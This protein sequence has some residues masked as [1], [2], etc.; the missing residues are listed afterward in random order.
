MAAS[1]APFAADT[2][3]ATASTA[4][5][6]HVTPTGAS[7]PKRTGFVSRFL[8]DGTNQDAYQIILIMGASLFGML[9]ELI[10]QKPSLFQQVVEA[11]AWY[12]WGVGFPFLCA[13]LIPLALCP[14]Y[15]VALSR[16]FPS[17]SAAAAS[18]ARLGAITYL[19]IH[20]WTWFTTIILHCIDPS[21]PHLASGIHTLP[22][23]A[24][25]IPAA[26]LSAASNWTT[27]TSGLGLLFV[28][29]L[30]VRAA[31]GNESTLAVT[32]RSIYSAVFAGAYSLPISWL[33]EC[34]RQLD[35]EERRNRRDEY[36]ITRLGAQLTGTRR[37]RN[38]VHDHILAALVSS[39]PER[40]TP[41]KRLRSAAAEALNL[42]SRPD[43]DSRI[44]D[45]T[46]LADHLRSWCQQQ[47][48]H[49]IKYTVQ[50]HTPTAEASDNSD[51]TLSE[52]EYSEILAAALEALR[53]VAN[54][55]A[56]LD[57]HRHAQCLISISQTTDTFS[58]SITDN[59]VGFDIQQI[60]PLRLGLQGSISARMQSLL[61]GQANI[62]STVGVGTSVTLKLKRTIPDAHIDHPLPLTGEGL[63]ATVHS[64]WGRV[65]IAIITLSC[66]MH[67]AWAADS[68]AH[69]YS[70]ILCATAITIAFA[71]LAWPPTGRMRTFQQHAALLCTALGIIPYFVWHSF[72]PSLELS[73][74]PQG[75]FGILT[76]FFLH[77]RRLKL[78]LT[79]Y[80]IV[81][82]THI[83]PILV[84][85]IPIAPFVRSIAF[86]S[87][88]VLT[89][90]TVIALVRSI[91]PRISAVQRQAHQA[92][93]LRTARQARLEAETTLLTDVSRRSRPVLEQLRSLTD[94]PSDALVQLARRVE[95]ELRDLI[96]VPRLASQPALVAAVRQARD[97]G[98]D[99]I[100]LDDSQQDSDLATA[101]P[102]LPTTLID[103]ATHILHRAKNGESVVLRLCPQH[104]PYAAT[105][106]CHSAAGAIVLERIRRAS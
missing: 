58:V 95:A 104:S 63:S 57:L 85:D 92:Q 69:L 32:T 3:S 68:P 76:V 98:V 99:V 83:I 15:L 84:L 43:S 106:Q 14:A 70:S 101:P 25:V 59:G 47:P 40:G 12:R 2:N 30:S 35:A 16:H 36:H 46:E 105:I 27:A 88:N 52:Y 41:A 6:A 21:Q 45:A 89:A 38:L 17:R 60:N 81:D 55:A 64:P 44:H 62:S 66:W 102:P 23:F 87:I 93:V 80:V 20:V 51:F 34:A 72:T 33:I 13:P 82:I 56:S 10:H 96:R 74:W 94:A 9:F 97:R 37:A 103:T 29:E 1:T 53:N 19:L 26:L 100:Q 11:P 65:G 49:H 71:S 7:Q 8:L 61:G 48:H 18:G 4:I 54:H 5:A 73:S 50:L 78:A 86:Q 22:A 42:L 91:E 31:I 77:Q 75:Y 24:L 28:L 67:V 90:A 79:S 39:F